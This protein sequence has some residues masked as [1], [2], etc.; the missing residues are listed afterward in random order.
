MNSV[1]HNLVRT[2][3]E[4]LKETSG[5]LITSPEPPIYSTVAKIPESKLS[6]SQPNLSPEGEH[7]EASP[8]N[9]L[10]MDT[11]DPKWVD[12]FVE[13]FIQEHSMHRSGKE[14]QDDLLFFV[15]F[16]HQHNEDLEPVFVKRKA[17][18]KT[19][20]LDDL[21]SW[22]ETFI[23]NVLSQLSYEMAVSVC[24]RKSIQDTDVRSSEESLETPEG[25]NNDKKVMV[26][27]QTVRK[28][29]FCSPHKARMDK[30]GS[31]AEF[32]YP[33]LYF[34][35]NDFEET[36]K[37]L[38]IK[39]GQYLCVELGLIVQQPASNL[40]HA[41]EGD[42]GQSTIQ[43]SPL[44][45]DNLII[46][47][48]QGAVPFKLLLETYITKSRNRSALSLHKLGKQI[49]KG[50]ASSRFDEEEENTEYIMM[51]GPQG[52][53]H[54]Q[55][56]IS[57][58]QSALKDWEMV[59]ATS[60]TGKNGKNE[61]DVEY[62]EKNTWKNFGTQLF[63]T[64]KTIGTPDVDLSERSLKEGLTCRMTYIHLPWNFIWGDITDKIKS[65]VH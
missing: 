4:P 15:R 22:K 56:A 62:L 7:V 25:S 11:K 12:L 16:P 49:F 19:P 64:L 20:Q 29:V 10:Q 23:L 50:S 14:H 36:F 13:Y 39:E 18:N 35:V 5:D 59:D 52:K 63:N 42:I 32:S 31:D 6:N 48:F 51:R 40:S 9:I 55:V 37:D 46:N 28:T 53:G 24:E 38:V 33:V 41:M 65:N 34:Y 26:P 27:V 1:L 2:L 3:L 57:P 58:P 61:E 43:E 54:A 45:G 8:N 30:K 44:S 21:V 47:L 17:G 60:N